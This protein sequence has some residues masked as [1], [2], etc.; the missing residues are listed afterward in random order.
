MTHSSSLRYRVWKR[1]N[2]L[3]VVPLC[4]SFLDTSTGL[5]EAGA[6][7]PTPGR[8]WWEPSAS[9]SSDSQK[10]VSNI[11][12]IQSSSYGCGSYHPCLGAE[13]VQNA[14]RIT[15]KWKS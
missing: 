10:T 14:L 11:S 5:D 1:V 8:R 7:G 12:C 3:Q 9:S 15:G 4:L 2:H 13:E 6:M